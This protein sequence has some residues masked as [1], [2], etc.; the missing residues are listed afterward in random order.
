MISSL[1]SDNINYE[2]FQRCL[3][4]YEQHLPAKSEGLEKLRLEQVPEV[5]E[6]RSALEMPFLKRPKSKHSWN[7]SCGYRRGCFV[8]QKTE[9]E[10][11]G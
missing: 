1:I 4:L 11:V 8:W 2:E 10:D 5:L 3:P 9:L 6:A 7:G